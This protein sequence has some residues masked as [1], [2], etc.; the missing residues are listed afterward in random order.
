MVERL[1]QAIQAWQEEKA[2][3]RPETKPPRQPSAL[4]SPVP[5]TRRARKK[6]RRR[7]QKRRSVRELQITE[8]IPLHPADL[9]EGARCIGHRD[10]LVQEVNLEVQTLCYRRY[11]YRLPDGRRLTASLPEGVQGHY[12]STLRSYVLYQHFRTT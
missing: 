9:P 3:E 5:P 2:A 1:V 6:K 7:G 12:G 4:H 11:R 8:T 10:F